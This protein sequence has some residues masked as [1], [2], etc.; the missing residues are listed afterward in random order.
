MTEL[1]EAQKRVL[2]AQVKKIRK[3]DVPPRPE[4]DD[5]LPDCLVALIVIHEK[6]KGVR[7]IQSEMECPVCKQGTLRYSIAKCN[8]HVWAGCSTKGCVSFMQ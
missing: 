4:G 2:R 7:G 6:H 8:G 3:P 1:T 5:D